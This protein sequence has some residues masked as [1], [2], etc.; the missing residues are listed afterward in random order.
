MNDVTLF[1]QSPFDAIRRTRPDG[2]EYW[3]ARDLMPPMGYARWENFL[4]PINR[5]RKTAANT[6]MD[7]TS[8][9]RGSQ[10]ISSTKPG[11]DYELTRQAAYLVAM[12]GDPNKPEVAAAQ[13]YFA[14]KT[15]EAELA[16][17]A[18]PSR[19]ELAQMVIDAEDRAEAAEATA[20]AAISVVKELAPSAQAW[21]QLAD[22]GATLDVGSAAK[23]LREN[24]VLIGRNRLYAY[25]REI[26]WVF[27]YGTEP[28]QSAVDAGYLTVDWGK[29]FTNEKTGEK[30]QGNAKSRVTTDGLREL[31]RRLTPSGA[32]AA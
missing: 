1:G 6:G 23:K 20:A 15:R 21:D 5:A 14:V 18:L 17:P 9:F 24:G 29:T 13:V 7:V 30:Q 8:N 19:R 10:K 31:Q 22:T 16:K 25:L 4:V 26:G 2:A 27:Q 32:G 28:K 12:N 11:D 3:T